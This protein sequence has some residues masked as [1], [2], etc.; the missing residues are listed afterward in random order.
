M[1]GSD[2][3]SLRWIAQELAS[4]YSSGDGRNYAVSPIKVRKILITAGAYESD[5]EHYKHITELFSKGYTSM[6][7]KEL[8]GLPM[9]TVNS[10]LPYSRMAYR[11]DRTG[12]ER[13]VGAEREER[14]RQRKCRQ[15]QKEFST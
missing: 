3:P 1:T 5:N 7:I 9:A 15:N 10:Y 13:S 11:M 4:R 6:E 14:Y 8:T 2:H 12:G